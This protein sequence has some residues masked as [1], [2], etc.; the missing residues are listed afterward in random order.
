MLGRRLDAEAKQDMMVVYDSVPDQLPLQDDKVYHYLSDAHTSRHSSSTEST[1]CTRGRQHETCGEKKE[2][3][4]EY[5]RRNHRW[6]LSNANGGMT[7]SASFSHLLGGSRVET[8][9]VGDAAYTVYY[10]SRYKADTR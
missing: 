4:K 6:K 3:G 5:N 1:H 10:G 7:R 9:F 8:A 2:S